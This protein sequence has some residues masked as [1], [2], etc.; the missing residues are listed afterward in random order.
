M[1]VVKGGIKLL[2]P[3]EFVMFP[4]I[5]FVEYGIYDGLELLMMDIFR[6]KILMFGDPLR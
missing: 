4:M 2:R 5:N 6:T 1:R 3:K